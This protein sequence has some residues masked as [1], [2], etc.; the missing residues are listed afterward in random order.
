M[1][2]FKKTFVNKNNYFL[3]GKAKKWDSINTFIDPKTRE[4]PSIQPLIVI[5]SV[6]IFLG[7]FIF[8]REENELDQIFT[9]TLDESVP[10]VKEMTLRRQIIRFENLGL[11]T[12]DLKKSLEEELKNKTNKANK[13]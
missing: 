2:K 4:Q 9:Q 8:L 11:D 12:S 7:Y 1:L 6:L 10:N 13:K 3:K 5:S